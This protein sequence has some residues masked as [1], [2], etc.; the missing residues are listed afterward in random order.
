MRLTLRLSLSL[1]FGVAAVSLGFAFYQ[2]H[3]ETSGLKHDLDRQS[4]VLAESLAKSV[5]PLLAKHSFRE[6]QNL[7][8]RL[9]DRER[10]AGAAV[11]DAAGYPVAI[12]RGL[13]SRLTGSPAAVA[14]SIENGTVSSEFLSRD[15]LGGRLHVATV[16]LR[17]SAR[18]NNPPL[19]VLAVFHEAAY[20]HSQIASMWQRAL[21]GVAI[22]TL[23]IVSITL[24]TLR[25]GVGRPMLA[26]TQWLR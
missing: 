16:P 17:D 9:K 21:T 11:Y 22:Q 18:D 19:G 2:T 4:R 10:I 20:I 12:T 1:I 26:M 6:L 25:W 13:D 7:T 23:L 24:L 3:T 8:D 5:E 14:Q 15:A